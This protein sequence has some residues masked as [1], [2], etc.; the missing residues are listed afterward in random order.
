[1]STYTT[2]TGKRVPI[3]VCRLYPHG[4]WCFK[5]PHCKQTHCHGPFQGLRVSHCTNPKSPNY[6]GSYY[7]VLAEDVEAKTC[8]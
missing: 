5:C 1:M 4:S 8:N 3:V 6:H 2:T 7:L